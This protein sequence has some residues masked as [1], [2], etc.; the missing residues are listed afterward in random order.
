M[1]LR[2]G[3]PGSYITLQ[4]VLWFAAEHSRNHSTEVCYQIQVF[5]RKSTPAAMWE[6]NVWSVG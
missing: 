6:L 2:A 5:E 1:N 4:A 3:R